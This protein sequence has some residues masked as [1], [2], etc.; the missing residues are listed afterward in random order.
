M[1]I[2]HANT[3]K[4]AVNKHAASL[5]KKTRAIHTTHILHSHLGWKSQR[6]WNRPRNQQPSWKS[7]QAQS[8]HVARADMTTQQKTNFSTRSKVKTTFTYRKLA[9]FAKFYIRSLMKHLRFTLW[10]SIAVLTTNWNKNIANI[11]PHNFWVL[12][13]PA[14][15]TFVNRGPF[16]TGYWTT[17][18]ISI[19]SLPAHDPISVAIEI[20]WEWVGNKTWVR[21]H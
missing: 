14:F 18:Y 21:F 1:C 16:T 13:F 8:L 15:A 7:K 20:P 10:C 9:S 4:L 11:F 5:I 17:S 3:A 12:E 2:L 6:K 19:Q